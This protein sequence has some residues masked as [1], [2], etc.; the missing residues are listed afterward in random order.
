[1]SGSIRVSCRI[2]FGLLSQHDAYLGRMYQYFILL[3]NFR[4]HMLT[5]MIMFLALEIAG[6]ALLS[7]YPSPIREI[8]RI[9]ADPNS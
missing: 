3:V 4:P 7:K 2:L 5:P 8:A 1:M 6:P 9:V